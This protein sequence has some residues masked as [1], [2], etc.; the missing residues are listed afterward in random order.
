MLYF[1]NESAMILSEI[2]LQAAGTHFASLDAQTMKITS[3]QLPR[4]QQL[5]D[6]F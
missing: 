6:T 2:F 4:Q 1:L 5:L 3:Q